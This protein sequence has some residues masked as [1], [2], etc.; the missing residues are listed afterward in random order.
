MD[1][2]PVVKNENQMIRPNFE[3]GPV[4]DKIKGK[5]SQE[6]WLKL[7]DEQ[8]Y[9]LNN[10]DIL[11]DKLIGVVPGSVWSGLSVDQRLE[12]LLAHE[13][14]PKIFLTA[15]YMPTDIEANL[16]TRSSP[17]QLQ[18]AAQEAA[19]ANFDPSEF[20]RLKQEVQEMELE[21]DGISQNEEMSDAALM[22]AEMTRPLSPEELARI[23]AEQGQKFSRNPL[24]TVAGYSFD[25]ELA[26]NVEIY[27]NETPTKSRTWSANILK[28]FWL[29][30]DP[31]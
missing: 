11:P 8:R 27:A 7:N 6:S 14:V 4:P 22:R 1:N 25:D 13:L 20:Q 18:T 17:D 29:S 31:E 28:K 2:N 19:Q 16:E 9:I 10:L 23:A 5:I 3:V 26:D 24:P 12:F 15:E 21:Q 30:M